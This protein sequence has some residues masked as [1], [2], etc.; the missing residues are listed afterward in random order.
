LHHAAAQTTGI[1]KRLAEKL[2]AAG[3]LLNETDEQ[4]MTP[5]MMAAQVGVHIIVLS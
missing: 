1:A 3:A 2:L 4:G 5:M